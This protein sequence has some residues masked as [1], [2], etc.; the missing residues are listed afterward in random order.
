MVGVIDVATAHIETP[1]EV[2]ETIRTA[3]QYVPAEN[4]IPCTN[5]GMVPLSREV[6]RGKLQALGQGAALVRAELGNQ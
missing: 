6:A 2:A 5:C 3:M 4:I 1:A